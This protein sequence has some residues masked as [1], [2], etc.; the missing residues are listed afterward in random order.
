[1]KKTLCLA[2]NSP[3]RRELIR[4]LN[5]PFVTFSVDID[6]KSNSN[7]PVEYVREIANEKADAVLEQRGM[8]DDEIVITADTCV[9]VGGEIMGK[10]G[11]RAEG[12]EMLK[13]LSGKTHTVST[14]VVIL[15][16]LGGTV[17]RHCLCE[18]TRVTFAE[19]SDGEINEYLDT[20]EYAD[21]AGAYAIQGAFSKHITGIEGDYNNVVGFP[22][23]AVYELL[24]TIE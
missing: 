21:K 1:M 24:K 8:G 9:A 6:E 7:D 18:T 10:P 19:L 3:R 14:G 4:Y 12:F 16:K 22:A 17:M 11:N 2:S 20:G 5:R 13:K 15:N 23:A